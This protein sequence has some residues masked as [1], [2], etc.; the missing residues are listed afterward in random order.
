[1]RVYKY[2]IPSRFDVLEKGQIRF[3]QP[4]AL[5]DPFECMPCFS[6]FKNSL[7]VMVNRNVKAKTGV[8]PSKIMPEKLKEV[9]EQGVFKIPDLL[10]QHFAVLCLSQ[11]RNNLLMWSH[12]TDSHKGFV[13]GFDSEDPFFKAG[14]GKTRDGLRKVHY[15]KKRIRIPLTRY[16]SYDDPNFIRSYSAFFFTKSSDWKYEKEVRLLAHPNTAT[17]TIALNDEKH[18]YLYDFPPICVR[19]IIFGYRMSDELKQSIHE[20]VKQKYLY[21]NLYQ[22]RLDEKQFKLKVMP[23]A[24]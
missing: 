13:V 19:E 11:V 3:T 17:L 7:M 2:L 16:K 9:V 23:I 22:T 8:D 4:V 10:S 24:T 15:S 14:Y 12:Y 18:L 20:V 21:A 1:M 5:N 6:E